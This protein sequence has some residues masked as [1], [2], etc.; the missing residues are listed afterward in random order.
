MLTKKQAELAAASEK[1]DARNRPE[2]GATA[3]IRH[4]IRK[5]D[6]GEGEVWIDFADLLDWLDELAAGPNNGAG[7]ALEIKEMLLEQFGKASDKPGR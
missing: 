2:G 3:T 6:Q 7:A 1:H 4:R 5:N